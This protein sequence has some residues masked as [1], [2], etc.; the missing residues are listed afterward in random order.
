MIL[1]Q[2]KYHHTF[3]QSSV[4]SSFFPVESVCTGVSRPCLLP[5]PTIS[6]LILYFLS[7]FYA[8]CLQTCKLEIANFLNYLGNMTFPP[9]PSLG[10]VSIFFLEESAESNFLLETTQ[11][12]CSPSSRMGEMALPYSSRSYFS[13]SVSAFTSPLSR[14]SL[15]VCFLPAWEPLK[16]RD[17]SFLP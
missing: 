12:I 17:Q 5:C 16:G 8:R 6:S 4:G 11:T 9:C 1:L 14:I 7:T 2:C 15:S 3:L 13:P 10:S